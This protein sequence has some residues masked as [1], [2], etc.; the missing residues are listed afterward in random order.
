MTSWTRVVT[1]R[2]QADRATVYTLLAEVELWPALCP[3]IRS[4]RV[5]RREGHRRL[6]VVRV[7]WRGLPLGYRAVVTVDPA[8]AS[9]TIRH[10]SRLTR[11]SVATYAVH[12]VAV[13]GPDAGVELTFRQ[14]V[15]VPIPLVGPLLA[16]A[17]VGGRVARDLGQAMLDRLNEIA[18]GGSLADRR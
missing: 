15:V 2:I 6:M 17:F 11:G 13:S 5:L 12:P 9:L 18:E 16:R 10:V 1:R 4:L 8:R 14:H 3:H 7:S